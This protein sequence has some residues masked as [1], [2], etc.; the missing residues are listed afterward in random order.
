MHL[1]VINYDLSRKL[2]HCLIIVEKDAI[3]SYIGKGK[4]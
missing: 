4:Q 3:K 1:H 2:E